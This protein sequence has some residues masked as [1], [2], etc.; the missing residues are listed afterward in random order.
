MEKLSYF[1]L[2]IIASI[3]FV[4][5]ISFHFYSYLKFKLLLRRN[6]AV[7]L[8]DRIYEVAIWIVGILYLGIYVSDIVDTVVLGQYGDWKFPFVVYAMPLMIITF[9]IMIS[10]GSYAYNS[11]KLFVGSKKTFDKEKVKIIQVH[12][13]DFTKRAKIIV[14]ID[15]DNDM[16]RTKSTR[17]VIRTSIK[18]LQSF[19]EL[20]GG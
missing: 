10:E 5:F 14:T 19:I 4:S 2:I 16:I 17:L 6:S 3:I 11:D 20:Y 12:K 13:Q 1:L 8:M 9:N 18:E 15:H 7:L